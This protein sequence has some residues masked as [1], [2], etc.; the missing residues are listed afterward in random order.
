MNLCGLGGI[1]VL[2]SFSAVVN[3]VL[4]LICQH[5]VGTVVAFLAWAAEKSGAS[6][7]RGKANNQTA[8]M[9]VAAMVIVFCCDCWGVGIQK[10]PRGV[11]RKSALQ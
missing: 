9:I 5:K 6:N 2:L 7:K 8:V 4:S 3:V 10:S 1:L 11:G